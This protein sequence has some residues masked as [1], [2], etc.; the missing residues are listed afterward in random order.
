MFLT[1]AVFEGYLPSGPSGNPMGSGHPGC[2]SEPPFG[3]KLTVPVPLGA[4]KIPESVKIISTISAS[5]NVNG[6]VSRRIGRKN[7]GPAG[8]N[9]DIL[10]EETK[11]DF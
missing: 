4:P 6:C 1:D 10:F 2:S 5:R 3:Q 11:D 7:P 8:S 9:P